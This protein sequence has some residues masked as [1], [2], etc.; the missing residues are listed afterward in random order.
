MKQIK[1]TPMVEQYL[2]IK[3]DYADALVFFR[4]GDFYELFFDDAIIASKVLEIALT[5]RAAGE[6][7]PMCG[8]PH[9]AVIPYL[10]K[11]IKKGFKVAIAEQTSE[12]GKG[13]VDRE[14][15]RLITPGQ[16]IDEGI[17]AETLNNYVAYLG[18]I[19]TG[20]VL[21]YVDI[22]TGES[23]LTYG[24]DKKTVLGLV[25][26]LE[27]KE[28]VLNTEYDLEINAFLKENNILVTVIPAKLILNNKI[29]NNLPNYLKRPAS[30]LISYLTESQKTRLE[31]LM[32]FKIEKQEEILKLDYLVKKH[33]ELLESNTNNPKTTLNYWLDKTETAMGS[34][35]L[36]HFI[37]QPLKDVDK[38]NERYDY[39]EALLSPTLSFDLSEH[40]KYVYD[41]NRIL[42][43][44]SLNNANAKDLANLKVSLNI[45]PKI[46]DI[47]IKANDEKLVTLANKIDTHQE[48]YELLEKAIVDYPPLVIKEGGI[49]KEGFNEELD[50]LKYLE[51][52]G[53]EWLESFQNNEREKTGIKNL[54]VGY[55]SV[56]GYYIEISKANLN[57]VLPEYNYDRKQ[58][59]VNSE[60]FITPELK[61]TETKLL[62]AKEKAINVEYELFKA[63]RD[64]VYEKTVSLQELALAIS[65]LDV[66]LSLAKAAREY[67]YVRPT[68]TSEKEVKIIGGRHPVVERT[69]DFVKNNVMMKPG[70][71]FLITG[72]NMSGKSTYMRMFALIVFMAQI[73]SFVPADEANFPLYDAIFTRIG[74]SDDIAGGKSTFMVEMVEANDALSNATSD[75][76]ILF[77]EIG[78]GTATYD[79]MAL[80]QGMIEYIHQK[81]KAQTLF[82]THYHELTILENSLERLTN[83]YVKA[84]NKDNK[85]I[86]LYQVEYGKSDR[87]YG[88]QVAALANL[89]ASLLKRSEQILKN[90]ESKESKISVDIFN[91]QDVLDDQEEINVIDTITQQVIDDL[92]YIDTDQM[93]P[94]EALIMIK[95]LQNKLKK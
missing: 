34:R 79:G 2:K 31:H 25:L 85:M 87:S 39:L 43:R 71:M 12:P 82:S 15:V 28:V 6:N 53:K 48:L 8:V 10:Q 93:T 49:I 92:K 35:L 55:T 62:N 89:P 91:Y 18:M 4:L 75:S 45:I 51:S 63:I 74:S 38:L 20:Y 13:L 94:L 90:L 57:L 37:N 67:N 58:T 95:S 5:K 22:S 42:G 73:G 60:R 59:L 81:I 14:V 46:K 80:A 65:S 54:K 32:A 23:Y 7:I 29:V 24:L 70:E 84:T 86:F 78:R 44:V 1:Y 36:K 83:L 61:E 41:I 40:L 68:L 16:V 19:E 52:H 76:L 26:T 64:K 11:L 56:F 17:L 66:Y 21:A 69:T 77:D 27:I 30:Q 72:P 9:H 47:L 50:Q 3:E 88:L 33:L